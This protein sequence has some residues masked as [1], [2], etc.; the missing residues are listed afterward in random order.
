MQLHRKALLL[1]VWLATTCVA[2]AQTSTMSF[3]YQTSA[4]VPVVIGDDASFQ[5]QGP[6]N[7]NF[8]LIAS[9]ARSH[10]ITSLGDVEVDVNHSS[11]VVAIDGFDP[12]HI[13]FGFAFLDAAGSTDISF[14]PFV[15][16]TPGDTRLY[17]QALVNAPGSPFGVELTNLVGA[18]A[19]PP[20]PS[21]A[22]VTPKTAIPGDTLTITGSHLG[23]SWNG[24]NTP[25]VSIDGVPLTVLSHGESTITAQLP[26][27]IKSG[28]LE[29]TTL[30][31]R[32][33]WAPNDPRLHVVILG[34]QMAEQA[35]P[36]GI[37]TGHKS[38]LGTLTFQTEVDSYI[39]PLTYGEEL[40]VEVLN[41]DYNVV[42]VVPYVIGSGGLNSHVAIRDPEY[43]FGPIAVDDNG[44]PGFA[45]CFGWP[46]GSTF[47][48][49]RTG[50]Y[51]LE[52]SSSF[53]NTQGD[54]LLNVWR[55]S[56]SPAQ[57]PIVYAVDPNVAPVGGT[58]NVVSS[59]IDPQNP[60]ASVVEFQSDDGTWLQA[61]P[62]LDFMGRPAVVVPAGASSGNL[63]VVDA[64]NDHSDF[65]AE[66]YE[67]YL[68]VQQATSTNAL[69]TFTS[70]S[71]TVV[72]QIT[73]AAPSHVFDVGLQQGQRLAVRA[74]PF[75]PIS[76]RLKRGYFFQPGILDPEVV[77]SQAGGVGF[78][79]SDAHSGPLTAAEIGGVVR[80]T[81]VA[82]Y[83][84]TFSVTMRGWLF[85][86]QGPY[87]LNIEVIEDD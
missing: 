86:S 75:D 82:P 67:S 56:P 64:N 41:F 1:A 73:A 42:D 74:F 59:G 45:A 38:I 65:N 48:A 63:R 6:A 81:W 71:M 69:T 46:T 70:T 76:Q 37:I 9:Q 5:V 19:I 30:G 47:V 16:G 72:D 3:D 11:F 54:Y 8:S 26:A 29:I 85:I 50:D 14:T 36:G 18:Q 33:P 22:L 83:S 51:I 79:L 35:V 49:P 68:L 2:A 43:A 25:V 87:I 52:V 80:P 31:G 12:N 15:L 61:T 66:E 20:R 40:R 27:N 17:F 55:E 39:V 34:Q 32:N 21:V 77:I 58:V 23:G 13:N 60:A 78:F 28:Y 44:G 24:G 84:G 4:N 57:N 7:T 62:F 53:Q 10:W